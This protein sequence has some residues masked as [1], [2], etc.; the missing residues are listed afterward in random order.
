MNE[1][2]RQAIREAAEREAASWPELTEE[3]KD[4]LRRLLSCA[5]PTKQAHRRAA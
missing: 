2:T 1:S 3:Q 5:T 4:E